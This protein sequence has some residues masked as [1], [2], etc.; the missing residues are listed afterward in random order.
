MEDPDVFAVLTPSSESRPKW[1][2]TCRAFSQPHNAARYYKAATSVTP[3]PTASQQDQPP[4]RDVS[5]EQ[6]YDDPV[7]RIMLK[8]SDQVIDLAKGLQFGRDPTTCDVLLQSPGVKGVSARH[9]N[10]VVQKDQSWYLEDSSLSC[11]TTVDY[12]GKTRN[13]RR[14]RE[15]WIIAHPLKDQK[16]W[17]TITVH[18]GDVAFDVEFPN[19]HAGNAE[20]IEKL[21]AFITK[22]TEALPF[23]DA[24]ELESSSKTAV[25]SGLK[26]PLAYS[27]PIY[28]D[29]GEIGKGAF[30]VVSKAMSN[31]DGKLYAMKKFN[32]TSGIM[33]DPKKR[34][35]YEETWEKIQ[36]EFS[37]LCSNAHV[38]TGRL[39]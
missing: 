15:R 21:E 28:V 30:S 27:R 4:T 13:E 23:V 36:R 1:R 29:K 3:E 5:P 16:Q 18:A 9:F 10:I 22:S 7:D 38:S 33:K 37:I 8:F 39:T 25:P 20:Y 24:L 26:T 34:R 31:R 32:L 17:E 12:D 14:Q 35:Q 6:P 19:Q 2:H 11:G